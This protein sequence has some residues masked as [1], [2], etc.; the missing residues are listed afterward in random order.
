[1]S[2]EVV[3]TD[4]ALNSNRL[5]FPTLPVLPCPAVVFP[6]RIVPLF[7]NRDRSAKAVDQALAENG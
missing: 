3:K 6:Y 1:M 7:V 2:M 4:Q 5:L